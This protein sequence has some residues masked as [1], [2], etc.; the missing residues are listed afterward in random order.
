MKFQNCI[1][2]NFERMDGRTILNGRTEAR[3][4]KAKAICH[5]NFSK[6]GDIK[7]VTQAYA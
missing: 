5:F 6:D 3:T 4:D 2:I 7:T 1:L